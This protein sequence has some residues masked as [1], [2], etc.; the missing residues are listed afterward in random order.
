MAL[1]HL[2]SLLPQCELLTLVD[3]DVKVAS[4]YIPLLDVLQRDFNFTGG[5]ALAEQPPV[6]MLLCCHQPSQ[7]VVKLHA[8]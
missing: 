1:K 7:T 4:M 6:W 3:L 2:L 8:L 5:W